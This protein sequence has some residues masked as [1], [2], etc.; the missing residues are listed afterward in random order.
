MNSTKHREKMQKDNLYYS[1]KNNRKNIYRIFKLLSK[2]FGTKIQT[3]LSYNNSYQL[4]VA[5][6]LS[7]QATD[8][9]VNNVVDELFKV[10]IKP[11]DAIKL[12]EKEINK[13]IKS[14]NYH[15]MKSKYIVK[16]SQQLIERFNG[17][18]PNSFEHLISLAG[19]GRK[20]ANLILSIYF[21]K[22]RIAVDTHVFRVSNRLGLAN[23]KNPIK[24]ERQLIKHIPQSLHRQINNLLIPFGRKYCRA[25]NPECKHCI[26]QKY[27]KQYKNKLSKN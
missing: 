24:T 17:K 20:T 15:N 21:E 2:N 8:K 25:I 5:I 11:E 27:C 1:V 4:L 14:I 3:E 19:V 16:M 26:L 13:Y 6:M 9:S 23:A 12:G 7:A 22:Q 10:L 18:V